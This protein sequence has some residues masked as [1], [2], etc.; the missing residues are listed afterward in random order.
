MS[1]L[2]VSCVSDLGFIS[3]RPKLTQLELPPSQSRRNRALFQPWSWHPLYLPVRALTTFQHR[4]CQPLHHPHH[5]ACLLT[6][7]LL[8]LGH[9]V[10]YILVCVRVPR[11]CLHCIGLGPLILRGAEQSSLSLSLF[12]LSFSLSRAT[13]TAYGGSQARGL[14]GAVATGLHQS[15]S[16]A[17]SEP[18]LQ[19]TPQ[20]H[21]NA[22]ALTP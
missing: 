5:H 20:A 1:N 11:I 14:M 6:G 2:Y 22:G 17:G 15:H 12:F 9:R 16:H 3:Q 19:P 4:H 21:G 13:P 7:Q 10:S 18:C 8:K